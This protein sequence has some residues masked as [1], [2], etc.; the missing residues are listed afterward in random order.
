M[1]NMTAQEKVELMASQSLLASVPIDRMDS[2]QMGVG[3]FKRPAPISNAVVTA[4]RGSNFA[5]EFHRI[6]YKAEDEEAKSRRPNADSLNQRA[7]VSKPMID[8][9][10]GGKACESSDTVQMKC[11]STA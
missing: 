11:L 5:D 4:K 6:F 10:L 7:S 3:L 1:K 8:F 2:V 9:H